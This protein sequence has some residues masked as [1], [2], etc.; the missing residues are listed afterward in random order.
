VAWV[1]ATT[2]SAFRGKAIAKQGK[3]D[4][5]LWIVSRPGVGDSDDLA[6]RLAIAP[7]AFLSHRP[8]VCSGRLAFQQQRSPSPVAD[9]FDQIAY[10]RKIRTELQIDPESTHYL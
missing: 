1:A 7:L 8:R 3:T 6:R 10:S 9:N 5:R 2:M 4:L